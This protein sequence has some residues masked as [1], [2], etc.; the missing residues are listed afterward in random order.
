MM[1]RSNLPPGREILQHQDGCNLFMANVAT[2]F[3]VIDE[4]NCP[5]YALHD[6]FI[7]NNQS[8]R[9]PDGQPSCLILVREFTN[10]LF[11]MAPGTESENPALKDRVFS[12]GGCMGL[13][14]FRKDEV[15]AGMEITTPDPEKKTAAGYGESAAGRLKKSNPVVSGTLEA[16][17]PSELLQFFHMH[18]KTGKLLLEVSQGTA[19]VAFREGSIIGARY[20]D[21]EDK[22]AIFRILG[23][24]WGKFSFLTGIPQSLMEVDAVGD[25][26][27]ILMEGL[28]RL[29]ESRGEK[30]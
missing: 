22:D 15:P 24:K 25:F 28:K 16:I 30:E 1:R 19:R 9:I 21:R 26:M 11:A 27:M 23:E 4:R 2:A 12:C 6:L 29:D 3:K 14:K 18:Q 5:F 17:S 8:L 13:I 20:G 10:I 7:L